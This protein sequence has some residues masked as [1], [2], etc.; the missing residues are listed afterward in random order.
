MDAQFEFEATA[1]NTHTTAQQCYLVCELEFERSRTRSHCER[2]RAI[3][4]GLFFTMKMGT[5]TA[6]FTALAEMDGVQPVRHGKTTIYEF[7]AE[8]YGI[9]PTHPVTRHISKGLYGS[10]S[11]LGGR[12]TADEM[13]LVMGV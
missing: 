12:P 11:T 8:P 2:L 1:S 6:T 13:V 4:S 5:P 7:D 10:L 9:H 3:A